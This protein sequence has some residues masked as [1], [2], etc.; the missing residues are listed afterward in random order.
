MRRVLV[1]GAGGQ[2]G[3]SLLCATPP[4]G[5]DV[6]GYPRNALD[7]GDADDIDRHVRNADIVVNTAAYTNVD[8]AETDRDR[9]FAANAEAPGLLAERCALLDVP[10]IHL[11]SDYVFDGNKL[12]PYTEDDPVNPINVYGASKAAGEMAVRRVQDAH[13]ILRTSWV[14][15]VHGRNFV[16][17][18]LGL[19]GSTEPLRIVDDQI[20]A[21]TSASDIA[22][23]VLAVAAKLLADGGPYGTF[24]YSSAGVTSWFG[25]AQTIFDIVEQRQGRRPPVEPIPSTDYAT[26]AT[27]PK[28]SVLDCG[29]VMAAFAPPRRHWQDGVAETVEAMLDAEQEGS[30]P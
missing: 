19:A 20:G 14:F 2:V 28:N 17:T 30:A 10:L 13:V 6:R 7:V 3:W 23:T 21:P 1:T 24:H 26:A 5:L 15:A 4:E 25:S 22:T 18:M 11:S 9:A 29:K 12:G 16:R 8:A 27:R